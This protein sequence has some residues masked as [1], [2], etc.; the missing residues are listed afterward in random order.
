MV[1][2]SEKNTRQK[3]GTWQCPNI[4]SLNTS[5]RGLEVK[6]DSRQTV[7]QSTGLLSSNHLPIR[8]VDLLICCFMNLGT[9][10]SVRLMIAA[11]LADFGIACLGSGIRRQGVSRHVEDQSYEAHG[12]SRQEL[13]GWE[14][15]QYTVYLHLHHIPNMP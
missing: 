12:G 1:C 14:K 7:K 5:V 9:K 13:S 2:C 4:S 3:I 10:G 8:F 11:S 15:Q 6:G